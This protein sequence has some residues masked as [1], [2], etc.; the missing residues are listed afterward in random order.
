MS[1]AS[2]LNRLERW[3][4]SHPAVAIPIA[5]VKKFIEDDAAGLG[6]QVAYWSFF[7]VFSLL[8]VFVSILGFAFQSDPA[9]Q[10]QVL[11]STLR[12]MPVSYPNPRA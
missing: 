7:S 11:D 10:K 2:V 6:V 4:A 3:Q 5:I 12:L 1:S 9:F 8:L